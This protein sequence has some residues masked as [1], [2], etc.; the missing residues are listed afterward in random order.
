[1]ARTTV[2]TRSGWCLPPGDAR[3]PRAGTRRRYGERCPDSP[4]KRQE[5]PEEAGGRPLWSGER[6]GGFSNSD[7]SR[8]FPWQ[9]MGQG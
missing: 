6:A 7:F 4:C 9:L 2:S 8:E 1:M 3:E 5:L